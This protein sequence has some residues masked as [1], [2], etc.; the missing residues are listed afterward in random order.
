MRVNSSFSANLLLFVDFSILKTWPWLNNLSLLP[1]QESKIGLSLGCFLGFEIC[2]P[3]K[4]PSYI[5][6]G[7]VVAS[8]GHLRHKEMSRSKVK[9]KTQHFGRRRSDCLSLSLACIIVVCPIEQKTEKTFQ[10]CHCQIT[11]QPSLCV[12]QYTEWK[13][14]VA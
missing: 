11:Y 14:M 12:S 13:P 3:P 2:L 8:C 1:E 5:A 6:V 4:K 10:I 9:I 7:V